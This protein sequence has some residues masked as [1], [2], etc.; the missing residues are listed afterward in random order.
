MAV[1]QRVKVTRAFRVR[2]EDVGE[3]SVIELD[4]P[5]AQ[6]AR[7]AKKAEFVSSDTKLEVKPLA[8]R[9]RAAPKAGENQMIIELQAQVAALKELVEKLMPPKAGKKEATANA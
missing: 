7:N 1:N 4:L 2:G 9:E 3:G 8:V 5:T 6:E